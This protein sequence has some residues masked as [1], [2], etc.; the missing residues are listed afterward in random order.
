MKKQGKAKCPPAM[1][2]EH[3]ILRIKTQALLITPNTR[4]IIAM[5]NKM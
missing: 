5:I 3:Q 4:A 1:T 2:D